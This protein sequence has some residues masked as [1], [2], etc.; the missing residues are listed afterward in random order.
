MVKRFWIIF[1]FIFENGPNVGFWIG[2]L[3]FL[4]SWFAKQSVAARVIIFTGPVVAIFIIV[5][6]TFRKIKGQLLETSIESDLHDRKGSVNE[7]RI[8]L[9]IRNLPTRTNLMALRKYATAYAKA[10][11]SDGGVKEINYYLD[12][13]DNKVTK[14]VQIYISSTTKRER[15]VFYLPRRSKQI[16]E[17]GQGESSYEKG[18]PS[19]FSFEYWREAAEKALEN[20]T[21]D[22]EKADKT[23]VQ[24]SPS[25][26]SLTINL[27]FEKG[28]REWRR[29]Y[30]LKQNSLEFGDTVIHKFS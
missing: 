25:Q 19:I 16:E 24:I 8:K 2:V 29:H 7:D 22:I 11:A 17:F 28:E 13:E 12:L 3:Y 9:L 26:D 4:N 23:R 27:T 5:V 20:S 1:K 14:D 6:G 30:Y 21:S 10:W 15:L 18:S